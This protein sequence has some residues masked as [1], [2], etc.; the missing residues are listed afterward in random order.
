MKR[1]ASRY[2]RTLDEKLEQPHLRDLARNPMQLAILLHL[3]HVL[4]PAL[5]EKRTT[6]YEEYM[7]LFFNREAEKSAVVRDHRE[8]LLAIH[9]VLAWV[10]HTQ[11][12]DGAGTGSITKDALRKEMRTY[13]E[14]QGHDPQLAEELLT[15][16]VERVGA[17]VSRVQGAFEFEVQPLREYF[18]AHHL[19]KTAPYSPVGQVR[20]GTRPERFQAIARSSYWTNVTRFFCG[21]YDVGE[22]S[23]LVDGLTELGE[24]DCYSLVNQPRQLAM[25][26]L[27]DRVFTQAPKARERLIRF[28]VEEP[29]FERLTS[30]MG[31]GPHPLRGMSLPAEAGGDYLSELCLEKL[32]KENDPSWCG[33]L[34]RLM[35]EN[36]EQKTL[37]PLWISRFSDGS[38]KGDPLREAM[39]FGIVDDFT[40]QE[41]AWWAKDNMDFHLHWLKLANHYETVVEDPN[42]Y[43]AAKK[44]FFDGDL[45]FPFRWSHSADSVTALEVL[46]ELLRPYA[47][48]ELFSDAETTTA[49][50]AILSR[51]YTPGRDQLLERVRQQY[52]K[53]VADSLESFAL[54]LVNLLNKGVAEWQ[55]SLTPWAALVDRGLDEAPGNY[56][57]AQIALIAAASRMEATAGVWDEDGFAATKGLAYRLFFARHKAED[58]DWWGARLTAITTETAI[59]CLTVLLSWG[60]PDVIAVLKAEID[61]ATQELSSRDWDR[62]W[63]M[64]NLTSWSA[65]EHHAAIPEDWFQTVGPF[66]PRLALILMGRCDDR[67]GARRVSRGYFRDYEGNDE[68]ILRCAAQTELLVEP[69]KDSVDWDYVRHLSQK[70]RRIG[71]HF[72]SP[73]PRSFSPGVPEAVAKAV[74][75]GCKEYHEQLVAMCESAYAM[76]VAQAASKVLHVA[77]ADNWFTPFD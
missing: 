65:R 50:H 76:T 54:F 17:L 18:A 42:L 25:M 21:F 47:L 10:L 71:V 6:L 4:G 31:L 27:S 59:Q 62:L 32:E 38:M 60:A 49:A 75:S 37:K 41:I 24:K 13:L 72:L 57:M 40:P 23:G 69:E 33:T 5:P 8:L 29:G 63:S 48:A 64:T 46:T 53:D 11:A 51:G 44:A 1:K 55:R 56:L 66:S 77:Q 16:S 52:D 58:A 19:Y 28:I 67:E 20:K 35:A 36:D 14:T 43:E 2:L 26:L 34:R 22:L 39:D 15:G 45:E 3:I 61:S 73:I 7:K 70:A 74:L 30:T 68:H 12:E 9:G